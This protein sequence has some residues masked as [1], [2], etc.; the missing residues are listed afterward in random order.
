ML[1]NI[2]IIL[3]TLLMTM[4]AIAAAGTVQL[5][6]TGQ[7][8]CFD[9][10]GAVIPCAG[11][12]QDGEKRAGVAWP[13]PRFTANAN[14]T[15]TDKL[16][17]L[18]WSKHA[19]APDRALPTVCPNAE[20][21]MSWQ[22]A[23]GFIQCL[24]SNS[25]LGFSDWRLPDLNELESMVNAGVADTSAWLNANGFGQP[26]LPKSQVRPS[27][28]WSSTSDAS[29]LDFQSAA[30]AWDI[31]LVRGD[32]SL[33]SEKIPLDPFLDTRGVWP[34]RGVS[35]ATAQL[36]QTGQNVCFDAAGAQTGCTGTGQNGEKLAGAAWPVPR[37]KTNPGGTLALDR[38]TGL[39]W[40]TDTQT[41]GP[42][43]CKGSGLILSWQEALDHVKCLNQS[44][45]SGLA[46]WRLPNR[47]ELRSLADSSK[48]APALPAGHPFLNE[49]GNSFWSSTTDASKPSRALISSLFDGS[50]SGSDKTNLLQALPVSGPDPVPPP[51]AIAQGNMTTKVATQTI[52]GTVEAGAAVTVTVNGA[53]AAPATVTG[54]TWSFTTNPLAAGT[55]NITV[56]AVDFSDNK[57]TAS[58]NVTF[59][60]LAP[61]LSITPVTTPTNK[62]SQTIAGTVEEGSTVT[63]EMGAATLPATVSGANWSFN[64]AGLATGTNNITIT[65]TDAVG[66]VATQATSITFSAPDGIITGQ[67]DISIYDALKALR[68]AVGIVAVTS[69]DL[70]RGDV[71]PPGS[72]DGKID[73]SDCLLILKK[74][75]GL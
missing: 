16:T 38:L 8:S 52:S 70:L 50:L 26:G 2:I 21:D 1:T 4:P 59:D 57:S 3:S 36:W 17:G 53:A 23:L 62:T 60:S 42:A 63:V 65:A 28:Y 56:T 34:V 64:A 37:F 32:F 51:L 20:E 72:P 10:K 11:T 7:T 24:N 71:A 40:A 9:A 22:Q 18:I 55:N 54:A 61:A 14:G 43:A 47:K 15:V 58:I 13:A 74:V 44:I 45:F 67:N 75:V 66:N 41:P 12:G 19:N 5:P 39:I 30:F 6:A 27:G 49:E 29:D 33:S 35:A 31:N 68:I 46:D 48:G 69:D 25:Y 73:V